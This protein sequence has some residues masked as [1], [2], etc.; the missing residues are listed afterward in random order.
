MKQ[1]RARQNGVALATA[2]LLIVLLLLL[3]IGFLTFCQRDLQFQR[4]QQ[5]S[6]Q[7]QQL[8]RAGIEYHEYLINKTPPTPLPATKTIDVISGREVIVLESLLP[9]GTF[10]SRG[11]VLKNGA[12]E[13][14]RAY[15][16]PEGKP[17]LA[18]DRQL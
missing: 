12:V 6:S 4:R 14:E 10:V 15:V 2:L 7:A 17:D 13:S 5:S 8:A 11:Q 9:D 3:G 16:V 18:Y 1:P